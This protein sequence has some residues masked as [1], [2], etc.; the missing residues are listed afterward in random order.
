M[1]DVEVQRIL[2]VNGCSHA[3]GS[4][5]ESRAVEPRGWSPQKAFGRHLA[6]ALGWRYENI[7]MPGGSNE[8]IV[9]TTVERIGRAVHDGN[10]RDLFVLIMWTGHA[11]FEVYDDHHQCWLNLCP[12]VADTPYFNEYPFAV[13]RYFTYH[14][15]VR[16]TRTETSTR[17]WLEVLLLQSY[18]KVNAVDYLF[19]NSY[20]ALDDGVQFEAFSQQ[21]D[22]TR[23]YEPFD[24]ARSFWWQLKYE[25]YRVIPPTDGVIPRGFQ[26]HYGEPGHRRWAE[27]IRP[28]MTAQ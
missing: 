2:L 25:G 6:D 3:A 16:T 11:R 19:C 7:A 8:R 22:R 27:H 17:F 18:L 24:E 14:T 28:V 20:Q 26:G 13:Q 9:R 10:V 1:R 4:D 15:L 12:G 21:L 5:I 23:Y